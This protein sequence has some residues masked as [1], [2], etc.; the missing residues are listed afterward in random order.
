MTTERDAE[1][2]ALDAQVVRLGAEN[3][4]LRHALHE[5]HAAMEAA[6]Q[7]LERAVKEAERRIADRA[8]TMRA[9][10]LPPVKVKQ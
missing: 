8:I 1:L 7:R 6:S 10:D 2:E 4:F 9:E 3:T 5:I